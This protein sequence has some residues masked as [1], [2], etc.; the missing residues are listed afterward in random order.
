MS[1]RAPRVHRLPACGV[2]SGWRTSAH[3]RARARQF[4]SADYSDFAHFI[5]PYLDNFGVPYTVLNVATTPVPAD[6]GDYSLVIVG[7]RRL[8]VDGVYLGA[9]E[10]DTLAAAVS[11]GTGLVNFDNEL[12]TGAGAARYSFLQ[13][14]FSSDAE[15]RRTG[16]RGH[17]LGHALHHGAPRGGESIS[18]GAMRLA[19]ITLRQRRRLSRSAATSRSSR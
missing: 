11:A 7:H 4:Q 8:D 12:W 17:V 6:V 2:R 3:R 5:Q 18:T 13:S 9:A 10:Q 19:G 14:I 15:G 16:I 1:R